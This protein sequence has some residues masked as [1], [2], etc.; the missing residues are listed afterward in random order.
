MWPNL[1]FPADLVTF[2]EEILNEKL[3]FCAG[4][5]RFIH[6]YI[7]ISVQLGMMKFAIQACLSINQ[8]IQIL[9]LLHSLYGMIHH[10]LVLEKPPRK[11]RRTATFVPLLWCCINH[12]VRYYIRFKKPIVKIYFQH[13][14]NFMHPKQWD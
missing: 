14:I 6:I 7:Y 10:S 2:T 9:V 8:T 3:L 13:W 4:F 11:R 12:L 5:G 1:Q